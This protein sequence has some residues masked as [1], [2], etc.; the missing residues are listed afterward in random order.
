VSEVAESARVTL[1]VADYAAADAVNKINCLGVGWQF[2]GVD[3]QTGS[4]APQSVVLMVD[5]PPVHIGETFALEV[6]LYDEAANELVSVP[7]PVGDPQPLRIGQPVTAE[8]PVFPGLHGAGWPHT[9]LI[10]NFPN[11]LPLM[12]GR[13]YTWR[14]RIDGDDEHRWEASFHVVGPPSGPVIG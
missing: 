11:G 5:V 2:A 4:T 8:R 9:Q 10:V 7:G 13:R 14:A 12:P 1:F 6:A 3:P